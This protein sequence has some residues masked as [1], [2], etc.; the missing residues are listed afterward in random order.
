MH[1]ACNQ[2]QK[3]SKTHKKNAT[4][5]SKKKH[6]SIMLSKPFGCLTK[7]SLLVI[8]QVSQVVAMAAVMGAVLSLVGHCNKVAG[9]ASRKDCIVRLFSNKKNGS[10]FSRLNT[11]CTH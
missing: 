6:V 3:D 9:N 5:K 8:R 10:F 4:K 2:N 1:S 11:T 7:V